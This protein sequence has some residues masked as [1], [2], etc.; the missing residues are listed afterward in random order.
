[1]D[2]ISVIVP[3]YNVEKYLNRCIES[4]VNQSY[5]NLEIILV[6]DGSTD[7]S[8]EICE[9]WKKKDSRIVVFHKEN[10]GASSARNIGLKH[11]MGEYI[12]FVDSDDWI[13]KN[14]FERL[15]FLI[16]EHNANMSICQMKSSKKMKQPVIEIW[17]K[18]E[19]LEHFFRVNGKN[20]IVSICRRLI[21]KEELEGY[22]FIEGRMNEDIHASYYLA[23]KC[24]TTV[25]TNEELY[26]YFKNNEGVTNSRF[27]KKK[28]DLLIIWEEVRKLTIKFTPDYIEACDMNC[29]RAKFTLLSQMYL[30]GYDWKNIELRSI[31][32]NLKKEVR[33]LF[34]ELMTL[35]MPI[36]RKIL[37]VLVCI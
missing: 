30:H 1:M 21:K 15:Y 22:Q 10:G 26:T 8:G 4:I 25:C 28:L 33:E 3:V 20:G 36:S 7:A 37:L 17:D 24:E 29:K 18:K 34:F 31:N 11:A 16:K 6:D 35:K 27:T 12:G 32:R 19:H 14:M 5:K 2:K 9:E 23:H 13:E